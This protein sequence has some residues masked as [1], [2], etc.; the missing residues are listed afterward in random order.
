MCIQF[1][2]PRFVTQQNIIT[3]QRIPYDFN[4]ED[5]RNDGGRISRSM[6]NTNAVKGVAVKP[7]IGSP[8]IDTFAMSKSLT[9]RLM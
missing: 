8:L 4:I 6:R 9:T 3:H 1:G 7:E 5:L 2:R